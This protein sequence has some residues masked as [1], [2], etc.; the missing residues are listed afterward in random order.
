DSVLTDTLD[1]NL[2]FGMITA[3][4]GGFTPGGAGNT[5]TFTLPTGASDGVYS[6]SYTATVNM[7]A[8]GSVGNNV[9]PTGGG[10]P[11]P[12]CTTCS[13][14]HPLTPQISVAKSADP[15]SGSPVVP[16]DT[17]TYT[18]TLQV[19]NGPTTADVVLTDTLDSDLT[20]GTVTNNPN[21]FVPGGSGNTRTF[22]LASGAATGT[23]VV[24]YTA[25]VN[26]GATGT[27]G[28]N[29]VPT[30]GGDP[31]PECTTC[32]TEH[33]LPSIGLAKQVTSTDYDALT[34]T[35]YVDY[36]F[37]VTNP[38]PVDLT[39]LQIL[40]DLRATYP[41]PIAFNVDQISSMDF[42]VNPAYDGE[43]DINM[44]M[45]TDSLVSG[46]SGTLTI[47]ISIALTAA[48]PAGPYNNTAIAQANGGGTSVSD[49][50]QDGANPDPDGSG[51]G[52]HSDPTPV[53]FPPITVVPTLSA[54]GM[55]LFSLGLLALAIHTRRRN[56]PKQT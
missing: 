54:W 11:D 32:M 45:G 37:L 29:V 38:G 7:G 55:I 39:D 25:T 52:N 26:L 18:L 4:T 51:P 44:L 49:V 46:G 14:S 48:T 28:N 43:S 2:T 10:D 35:F 50:S 53:T 12:E 30:G 17:L 9:V 27:V 8:N 20:F 6:V 23:Y 24:S 40:D 5:R 19:A 36:T 34:Q 13:T 41:A 42:A 1:P 47:S 21:G 22:T 3:N 31:D 16:G 33:P 56:Q 15:A